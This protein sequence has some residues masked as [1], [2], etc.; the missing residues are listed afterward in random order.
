MQTDELIDRLALDVA[1]VRRAAVGRRF[2][3][4]LVFGA[5]GAFVLLLNWLHMRPDLA[6]A[7]RTAHWWLK[8]TYGLV[9]AMAGFVAVERLSRP[10][11]SG[12]RGIGLALAA[13]A[14][15][16][17]LGAAQLVTTAPED[18]M[19]VWLGQSWRHCPY[20]IL[21]LSGPL[22]LASLFVARGLAPTRLALAGAACG[23]F[24]GGAAMAVYC[25]H[26]PETEPA[27]IATWYSAGAI[28]TTAVGAALGRFALRWR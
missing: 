18:R 6:Q 7:V 22:L 17:V 8:M 19:S 3:V 14:L 15:L 25:L 23:L 11:G 13:F 26:C 24:A 16:V 4:A 27:F 10:A 28:L 12:R 21:A 20:N 1:P 2:A 9:L 5:A